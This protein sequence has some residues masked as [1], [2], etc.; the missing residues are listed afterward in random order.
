WGWYEAGGFGNVA[1]YLDGLDISAFD[2]KKPPPETQTFDDIVEANRPLEEAELADVLDK[3]GTPDPGKPGEIMWPKAVTGAGMIAQ[4]TGA[5]PG[6]LM[7]QVG[8]K[9]CR[10]RLPKS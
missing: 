7:S 5:L 3:L 8:P 9:A 6:G 2:P 1:A 10:Y 4:A